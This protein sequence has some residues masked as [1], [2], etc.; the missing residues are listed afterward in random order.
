VSYSVAVLKIGGSVFCG[1]HGYTRAAR[2]IAD[3]LERHP[4]ERIVAVVSAANGVTDALLDE[5]RSIVDEPDA[6]ALDLLWSTGETKS[7]A[8]LTLKLHALGLRAAAAS[9]HQAGLTRVRDSSGT[10]TML[11]ALR[12][13]ALL[14]DHDVIVVPGFLAN[15][16][17]GGIVS[18]GRGGSDLTA[19]IIAAG[20]GARRCELLKDVDGYF[21]ADPQ[22]H[23]DAIPLA[24]LTYSH[25]IEMASAGC[26]VVQH[27]ALETAKAHGL[28]LI[29]RGIAGGAGTRIN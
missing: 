2:V 14:L 11:R 23:A 18:L 21:T 7:V 5:A 27:A 3:R 26:P 13:R 12:L 20:L 22:H 4:T 17:G 29:V 25:A 28:E 24:S 6:A 16:S 9:V 15:T 10:R 19:V 8:L 1:R